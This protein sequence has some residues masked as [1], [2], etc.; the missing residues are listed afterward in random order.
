MDTLESSASARLLGWTGVGEM[1]GLVCGESDMLPASDTGN[2]V[3]C[4]TQTPHASVNMVSHDAKHHTLR[5]VCYLVV[6]FE[7]FML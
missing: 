6:F 5:C 2:D 1:L 4:D 3:A 7:A